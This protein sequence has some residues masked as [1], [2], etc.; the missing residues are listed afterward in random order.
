MGNVEKP[1]G[2]PLEG[3]PTRIQSMTKL[4]PVHLLP[5]QCECG[6]NPIWVP[7]EHALYFIDTEKRAMYRY[8][9]RGG[10]LER[11]TVGCDTQSI[12]RRTAFDWVVLSPTGFWF[13]NRKS[14]AA[15]FIGNPASNTPEIRFCDCVVDPVGRLLAGTYNAEDFTAADG[16]IYCL[17]HDLSFRKIDSGLVFVNGMAFGPGGAV[18]YAAEMFAR[19][20]AAYD[21]DPESGRASR[22]RVFAE[23][24]ERMGYPD[25][26]IVDGEGYVW[27]G[28]WA[29]FRV[30]RFDPRG[31]PDTVVELPVPTATCMAFGGDDLDEL[32]ITTARKG[33]TEAE[34]EANPT[35]GDLFK[36]QVK[37]RGV[38]EGFFLGKG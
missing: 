27:V 22:R 28:H 4:K 26:V 15:E 12:A 31:R 6:E 13:W 10:G 2:E 30:T 14:G 9:P 11:Y 21:F 3:A 32:Y 18:L 35:S 25:G 17:D 19:R 7:E 1:K 24:D 5:A 20:I 8:L 33:L 16:S 37:G 38:V 36:V 34:L 23:F 29:G